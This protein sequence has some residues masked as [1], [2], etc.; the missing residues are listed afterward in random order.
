MAGVL[1]VIWYLSPG[2]ISGFSRPD[3]RRFR[4][5]ESRGVIFADG[6]ARSA[7][8]GSGASCKLL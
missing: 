2:R 1:A 6:H 7:D 8:G 3:D 5:E 4:K